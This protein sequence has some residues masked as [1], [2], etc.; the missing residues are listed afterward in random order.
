MVEHKA[1]TTTKV[2]DSKTLLLGL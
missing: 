1:K 2:T